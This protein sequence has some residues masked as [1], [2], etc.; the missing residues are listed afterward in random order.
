MIRF[1]PCSAKEL[2]CEFSSD[3][4]AF[5]YIG[6]DLAKNGEKCGECAFRLNGYTMDID[7]VISYDND[8][9]TLEGFI[10]SALNYGANRNAYIAHYLPE[11]GKEVASLLGFIQK[12]GVLTGEIPELLAGSCCKHKN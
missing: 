10:R 3:G 1:V 12:D 5:G 11:N 9:E 7:Y 2:S 8:K 4:N 6:Y